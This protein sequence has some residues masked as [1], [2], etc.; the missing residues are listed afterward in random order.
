MKKVPY[1]FKDKVVLDI[2]CNVGGML[3]SLSDKI[4]IGIGLDYDYRLINAA[5]AIK[6]LNSSNNL[7]FYMFDLENEDLN[8]INNYVLSN[9]E[10]VDICFLL[11]ICMWIKNWKEVIKF[12]STISD[13]LLFETNGTEKQQAEQIEELKKYYKNIQL[14]EKVSNDD[15]G[16]PYRM[17]VLCGI[18]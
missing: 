8:L 14:I 13:N 17:L 9:R 3:H 15:P 5:N 12:I 2:G 10:K 7:S 11:S 1:D 16:Q 18:V 4:G 6:T